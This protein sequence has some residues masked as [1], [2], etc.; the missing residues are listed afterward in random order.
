MRLHEGLGGV[1]IRS[2]DIYEEL[3]IVVSDW[4]RRTK[5]FTVNLGE[6]DRLRDEAYSRMWLRADEEFAAGT[7][8]VIIDFAHPDLKKRRMLYNICIN[9]GAAPVLVLCRCNDFEEVRRRFSSRRG[10]EA[11]PEH[12]ASDLSV[13]D[14]IRRRWEN[15]LTDLLSNGNRPTIIM[16]D[17]VSGAAT[18]IH[19]TMPTITDGIRAMLETRRDEISSS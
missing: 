7:P 12:E 11:E 8:I 16:Y 4:I 1:L 17:T 15:P 14:D 19:T 9:R 13:L 6:Y 10:R 2:C 18:L 5:G 3:G